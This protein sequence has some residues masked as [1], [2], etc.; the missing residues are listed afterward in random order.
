MK[1]ITVV[2]LIVVA[3]LA[4]YF[5]PKDLV[6][7]AAS[8]TA[9]TNS[10]RFIQS[11]DSGETVHMRADEQKKLSTIVN[12]A[13][14]QK[15]AEPGIDTGVKPVPFA[16]QPR[17]GD[18]APISKVVQPKAMSDEEINK[19]VPPPFN[20]QLKNSGGFIHEKFRKFAEQD[21]PNDKDRELY[22]RLS[23]AILSNPYAKFL[24]VE[25]LQCKADFCE[26]R[27]YERKIGVWSYIQAEMSLQDWWQFDSS[28]ASGFET[29]DANRQGWYVLLAKS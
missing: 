17:S 5:T 21:Q 9:P 15:P 8:I 29:D 18:A 28:H 3:Y 24:D 25:S 4:G 6:T 11:K 20:Q 16:Q 13:Q 2:I 27:L 14:S 10:T 22:S 26:I 7:S 23:N 12:E 19:L 1:Y